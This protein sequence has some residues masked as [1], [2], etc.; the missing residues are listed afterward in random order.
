MK[1]KRLKSPNA[2]SRRKLILGLVLVL[3]SA[4]GVWF[5][6]DANNHTEEFL[7]AA[8]PVSG[9]SFLDVGSFK[10]ARLNLSDTRDLYLQPGDLSAGNYIMFGAAAG[11]LIPKAWISSALIDAR[12][13]VVIT[14]TMPLPSSVQVGDLVDVWVSK[15]TGSNEFAPPVQLALDAEI[16]E[17]TESTGMLSEQGQKVQVLV[18]TDSVVSIL[19]AIA[20]KDALSL[21][22]QR[23]LGND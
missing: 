14:S 12:D 22:L 20:S 18:P 10:I 9:G 23:N 3:L 17:I 7:V 11:Q 16:A 2:A 13:P 15:K 4:A 6:I 5:T 1:T 19:D 21:V 8:K